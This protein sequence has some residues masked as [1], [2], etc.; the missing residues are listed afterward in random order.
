MLNHGITEWL[1]LAGTLNITHFQF[2]A[3][4]SV[5]IYQ[6]MLPIQLVLEHLMDGA[7]TAS[8]CSLCQC[9]I[10]P[11]VKNFLK[12]S[13]KNIAYIDLKQFLLFWSPSCL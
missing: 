3:V 5:A 13:D 2:P 7:P 9:L 4:G 8:Q 1:G 6:L 11:C 12:T 10:T